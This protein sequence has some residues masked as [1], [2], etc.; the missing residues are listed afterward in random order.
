M[1]YIKIVLLV[2]LVLRI[3]N[4]VPNQ[5]FSLNNYLQNILLV[6]LLI[7]LSAHDPVVAMLVIIAILIN[8]PNEYKENLF[9]KINKTDIDELTRTL[10]HMQMAV[11]PVSP[12]QPMPNTVVEEPKKKTKPDCVPEFIISKEMLNNAQNNL[13]EENIPLFP[14]EMKE[15]HVNIQGYFADI[16]GFNV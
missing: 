10:P 13:I 8:L 5:K 9:T 6:A 1:D 7:L 16:K 15:K 11:K 12:Q 3:S 2:Y 4:I 14:N